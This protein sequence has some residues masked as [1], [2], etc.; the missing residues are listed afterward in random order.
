MIIVKSVANT[1]EILLLLISIKLTL[2]PVTF[3]SMIQSVI[4]K[5]LTFA[6]IA[7]FALIFMELNVSSLS[8]S[9][10]IPVPSLSISDKSILNLLIALATIPFMPLFI[11]TFFNILSRPSSIIIPLIPKIS[12]FSHFKVSNPSCLIHVLPLFILLP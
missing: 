5:L 2:V 7:S 9:N 4:F 6:S 8:P 3:P 10:F 1:E 12:V 11:F